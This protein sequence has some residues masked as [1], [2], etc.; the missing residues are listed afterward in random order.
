MHDGLDK[1]F[2]KDQVLYDKDELK[3]YGKDWT[4][5]YEPRPSAVVFPRE[6]AQVVALVKWAVENKVALVPS[7]GRTG[8]SGAAVSINGEI[9]VSFEKMN[10]ILEFNEAD[11]LI[12]AQPGVITK[13]IQEL[14]KDKGY[15]F[16]VDFASS[17]SSQIG[18]NVAT[19]AGGLHVLRYGS[20]R[21][22]VAG[23]EVVT[24]KGECL[25]LNEGLVKNAT[26]YDFRHLFL[27]SE[28]TLG[29]F[30]EII[31]RVCKEPR[32]KKVLLF[33]VE[34]WEKIIVLYQLAQKTCELSAFEVFTNSA[35]SYVLASSDLTQ[36][37]SE[38]SALY[39]VVE[40]EEDDKSL[41]PL[42]DAVFEKDLAKDGTISQNSTQF[43][44]LWSYRENISESISKHKPYKNDVS[45]LTS[46]IPA[47]VQEMETILKKNYP[48][49]ETLWFGHV[50]DGNLHINIL[51]PEKVEMNEFVSHCKKVDQLLFKCIQK[52]NG[53]IS[54]EHGVGLT[55]KD[56]LGF[57]RSAEEI[58]YMRGI[59]KLFD[60]HCILNPGKIFD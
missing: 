57:T 2:L 30:T 25:R 7:G 5:Y 28:G 45:V 22:W 60:P 15:F 26:G 54:A 34:S 18:G 17:G 42:I 40:A 50:G 6:S 43:A 48:D 19:N 32:E 20:F 37:F 12:R 59:K 41:N 44:E 49:F 46:K 27:G 56:F 39:V 23:L 4:S 8:L 21:S 3:S 31:L 29:L 38:S 33:S 14:A 55:K 52:F 35:L 9:V 16:P 47:F 53:S 58:E 10:K 24:G 11:L 1:I 51:K 13:Q 36:P